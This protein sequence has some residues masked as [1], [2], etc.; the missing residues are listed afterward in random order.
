VGS[1]KSFVRFA[2]RLSMRWL[3]AGRRQNSSGPEPLRPTGRRNDPPIGSPIW[4][5]GGIALAKWCI[6]P[7]MLN[8]VENEERQPNPANATNII[9]ENGLK[10]LDAEYSSGSRTSARPPRPERDGN[11]LPLV[12]SGFHT[13]HVRWVGSEVLLLGAPTVLLDRGAALDDAGYRGGPTQ[14]RLPQGVSF[15]RA[16]C[17]GG[18]PG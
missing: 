9:A 14:R 1:R 17:A 2:F 8:K 4:E 7:V 18:V 6:I 16:R 3:R 15:Q 10:L 11:A 12:W 13:A 5:R